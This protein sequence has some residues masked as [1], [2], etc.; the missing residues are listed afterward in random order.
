MEDR[1]NEYKTNTKN[2]KVRDHFED[3]GADG[4]TISDYCKRN[5]MLRTLSRAMKLTILQKARNCMI[6][7]AII[8]V[9]K[10]KSNPLNCLN[11]TWY[12]EG[13]M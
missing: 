5:Y 12:C 2:R 3:R 13:P 11:N 9:L 6:S 1:I 10:V 4:G 7:W 8:G